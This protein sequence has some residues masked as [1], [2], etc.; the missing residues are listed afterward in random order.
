L[1]SRACTAKLTWEK[2][3]LTISAGASQLDLDAFGAD[4]GDGVPVAAFQIRKVDS[5]CCMDYAIYSLEKPPRLLRTIT[6]GGFFSASDEDLDG[7]VEIWT[8]DAAA[9]NGLEK[10]SLSELDSAPTVVLRFARGR[11]QDLS[12]EFQHHFGEEIARIRS[13][14]GPQDLEYF[15]NGDGKLA[16]LPTPA[17]AELLHRLR[18]VKIKILEIVWTYLYSGREQD[19]WRSLA[20]MWPSS[21]IERIRVTLVNARRH[22]IQSQ[23]DSTTGPPSG[24]RKHVHVFNAIST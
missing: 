3:S 8:D 19:A 10:L 18:I 1:A 14:I 20:E 13:D 24:K 4:L 21:D 12:A 15:K 9:V 2:Q 17:T 11:L 6:G 22:G 5:D 16:A 7:S 23:A